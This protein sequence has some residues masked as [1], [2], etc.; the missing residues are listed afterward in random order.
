MIKFTPLNISLDVAIKQHVDTKCVVFACKDSFMLYFFR[1]IEH[2]MFTIYRPKGIMRWSDINVWLNVCSEEPY[3]ERYY[4]MFLEHTQII[5]FFNKYKNCLSIYEKEI[6]TYLLENRIIV[7]NGKYYRSMTKFGFI[8]NNLS[9]ERLHKTVDDSTS[10]LRHEY[11][12]FL[13]KYEPKYKRAINKLHK[14]TPKDY[15]TNI[16]KRF[17]VRQL[18]YSIEEWGCY[19]IAQNKFKAYDKYLT[20]ACKKEINKTIKMFNEYYSDPQVV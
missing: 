1:I 15:R 20:K 5:T 14:S 17:K 18:H 3:E 11:S 4:G 16:K 19:R 2:N 9:T 7:K 10:I 13:F 8:I 12:H 6:L